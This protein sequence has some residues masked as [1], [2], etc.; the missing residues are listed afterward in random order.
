MRTW[1]L[2]GICCLTFASLGL[3]QPV[4]LPAPEAAQWLNHVLPLPQEV[5]LTAAVTVHAIGC[6]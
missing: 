5:S 4:A 2:L 6:A 3:A 1:L